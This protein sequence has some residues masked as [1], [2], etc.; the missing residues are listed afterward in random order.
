MPRKVSIMYSL[1]TLK[2]APVSIIFT[3]IAINK[4]LSINWLKFA[5]GY[6]ED[7]LLPAL[8]RL[9]D[10]GVVMELPD[11]RWTERFKEFA[12]DCPIDLDHFSQN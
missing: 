1:R 11:G 7:E 9:R 12:D 3:F 4:P 10:M 5:T 2:G 8:R 6:R